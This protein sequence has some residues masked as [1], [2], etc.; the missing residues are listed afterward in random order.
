MSEKNPRRDTGYED[1]LDFLSFFL[2]SLL[3][4]F[5]FFLKGRGY[6]GE[7]PK[8]KAKVLQRRQ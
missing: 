4:F 5:F 3:L 6:G 1:M 8:V 7:V 2:F